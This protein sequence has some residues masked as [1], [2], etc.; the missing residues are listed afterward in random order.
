MILV[1][2]A[3]GEL[4][5]LVVRRLSAAGRAVRASVRPTS[6]HGHFRCRT[7]NS[8]RLAAVSNVS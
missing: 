7:C 6:E 1:V 4:G 8:S 2:G 5:S 3:T